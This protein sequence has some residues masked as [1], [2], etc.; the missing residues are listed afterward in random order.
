MN[1]RSSTRLPGRIKRLREQ[2]G[3]T[4]DDVAA[5]MGFAHR[6][7]V[8]DIEAGKRRIQPE[9][10]LRLSEIFD[11]DLEHLTDP[12][13]LVGEGRF[14]FRTA[15]VSED[16]IDEFEAQA[17]RWIATYRELRTGAGLRSS[18]LTH[19]L[20]LRERSSFEDAQ[21]AGEELHA[22]WEL[23]GVPAARLPDAI[24]EHLETEVLF[25]DAP[26]GLSGAAIELPGL[27]AVLIN[28]SEPAGRRNFD[29]AHE[30]FHLL[31]WEAMPPTR[32]E[33]RE[34]PRR[35]G[36]RVERLAENFAGALLMPG[37]ILRERWEDRGDEELTPWLNRTATDLQVTALALKWRLV[38]AK[39]LAQ[40]D[41]R[42]I[43]DRALAS[44]GGA[45]EAPP[46]PPFS[47]DFVARVHDA[48]E[49]G[50][51]SLRKATTL[52]GVTPSQFSDLCETYGHTLS[53]DI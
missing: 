16:V 26:A 31:T 46:P 37:R 42:R 7:T 29:L 34:I 33:Q 11:V 47:P 43:D 36:N 25:V 20:D 53:Y 51:L 2:R 15:D 48:V 45:A 24:R 28:R 8:A 5:P 13:R 21:E 40:S 14:N 49:S 44:N 38:A 22:L 9:E 41:A 39:L 35:K 4:Q 32:V 12:F 3:L 30:L 17:G 18:R 27:N 1:R 50:R 6:Q 23:G 52:L 10:L 19:K